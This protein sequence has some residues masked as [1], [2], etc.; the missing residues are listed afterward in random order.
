MS[1]SKTTISNAEFEA[2]IPIHDALSAYQT[3]V[4]AQAAA[5]AAC[6]EWFSGLPLSQ[7]AY[8]VLTQD[9]EYLKED[10]YYCGHVC[11]LEDDGDGET[12]EGSEV[13]LYDDLYW[14]RHQ[15]FT[16]KSILDSA[17]DDWTDQVGK[18]V[19]FDGDLE[20]YQQARKDQIAEFCTELEKA[21]GADAAVARDL[22]GSNIKEVTFDW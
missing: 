13:S 18:R 1:E 10:P 20:K 11:V 12:V 5:S 15:T 17:L 22:L 14:E 6:L 2:G 21:H 3:A 16:T 7:K 19:R 8:V 9:H 4:A